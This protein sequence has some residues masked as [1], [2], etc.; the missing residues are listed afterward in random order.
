MRPAVVGLAV[1]LAAALLPAGPAGARG[2]WKKPA[3]AEADARA[4]LVSA[5]DR[6]LRTARQLYVMRDGAAAADL[7]LRAIRLYEK[8]LKLGADPELHYRAFVA[9]Q[10]YLDDASAE[11][12]ELVI[13]HVDGLRAAEPLD[14][15]DLDLTL[16]VAHALAKL[17]A[18]GRP[19]WEAL[20]QRCIAEY[21]RFFARIDEVDVANES[22]LHLNHTNVAEIYMALGRLP[23]AIEHYRRATEYP[24][25]GSANRFGAALVWYGL[26]VAYDRDGQW[27]SARDAML[28]ALEIDPDMRALT[29]D[30]VYFVPEGDV[31]YYFA[32]GYQVAGQAGRAADRYRAFLREAR[33]VRPEYREQARRRLAEVHGSAGE[34]GREGGGAR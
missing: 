31:H 23:E 13:R 32:L 2:I 18:R 4:R 12:W 33:T 16:A 28:R 14:P 11:K 24:Y 1:G 17:G 10:T 22:L 29:A 21:E 5:A 30:G 8:A 20:F 34:G 7:A 9:A 15:R 19:G 3:V 6:A 25:G 26:A 27:A